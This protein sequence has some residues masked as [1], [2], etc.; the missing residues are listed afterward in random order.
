MTSEASPTL[1]QT[2]AS[3]TI[4]E[5]LL[6]DIVSGKYPPETRLPA[7]R[8]LSKILGASRPT[9]REALRRLGEWNLIVAKRGSGILVQPTSDWMLDVLP[10][11][12]RY[13]KPSENEPSVLEL[14]EDLMLLR[15][16]LMREILRI[17]ASR[18]S[19]QQAEGARTVVQKAWEIRNQSAEFAT[20]DLDILR[21]M[22]ESASFMPGL[23]LLNQLRSIYVD[24]TKT[25]GNMLPPPED[26]YVTVWNQVLD[27]CGLRDSDLALRTMDT[28]LLAH[29]NRLLRILG[30]KA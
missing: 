13:A 9:L 24:M 11:Y 5:S 18:F 12:M 30:Q 26:N 22:V 29:D 17:V 21:F 19:P 15:R 16:G 28:Y 4:F 8:E 10:A 2:S 1:P 23:W 25:I 14:L 27:A 7:E 3:D 6:S 20:A